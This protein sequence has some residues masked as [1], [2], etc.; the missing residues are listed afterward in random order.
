MREWGEAGEA[1]GAG[2]A[3]VAVILSAATVPYPSSRCAGSGTC[4]ITV[5]PMLGEE[6]T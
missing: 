5:V 3:G 4:T 1:G 2:E 6:V